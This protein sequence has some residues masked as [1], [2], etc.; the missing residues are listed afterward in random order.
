MPQVEH[1][2]SMPD[3]EIAH[4]PPDSARAATISESDRIAPN[5]Q[6]PSEGNK[7]QLA[8]SSGKTFSINT[9][10]RRPVGSALRV[11]VITPAHRS[12]HG[13]R[14]GQKLFSEQHFDQRTNAKDGPPPL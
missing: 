10:T 13:R 11:L 4:R 8:A 3:V 14:C 5:R 12:F 6:A 1:R 9:H 2:T 7:P